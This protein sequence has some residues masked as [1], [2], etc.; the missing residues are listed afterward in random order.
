MLTLDFGSGRAKLF[1]VRLAM[2]SHLKAKLLKA[3]LLSLALSC[4][5]HRHQK[6]KLLRLAM[7][8]QLKARLLKA[9]LL[10]NS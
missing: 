2:L 3:R 1:N 4:S 7:L 10:S 6:A 9:K 8:S 5:G